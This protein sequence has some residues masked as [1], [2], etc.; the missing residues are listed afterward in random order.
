MIIQLQIFPVSILILIL[1][2][3]ISMHL[4]CS[5]KVVP[6]GGGLASSQFEK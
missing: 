1:L 4:Y 2:K 6:S 5:V 3:N